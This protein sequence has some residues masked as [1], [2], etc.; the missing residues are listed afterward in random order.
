MAKLC[1][2]IFGDTLRSTDAQKESPN[3]IFRFSMLSE[4]PLPPNA[5]F[6]IAVLRFC[7][8]STR[9]SIVSDTYKDISSIDNITAKSTY[10]K[11]LD[12]YSFVLSN[13]VYTVNG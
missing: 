9:P 2:V 8:S 4:L 3:M 13:P 1:G 11:M 7:I 12:I 6:T 5:S 10:N